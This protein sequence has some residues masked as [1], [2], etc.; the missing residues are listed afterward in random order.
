ME[1]ALSGRQ[2][3]AGS[4]HTSVICGAYVINTRILGFQV[5]LVP[6]N[7]RERLTSKGNEKIKIGTRKRMGNEFTDRATVQV[8]FGSHFSFSSSLW[9]LLPYSLLL[10]TELT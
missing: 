9:S 1:S 2:N 8:K 6:P 5:P 4:M 10:K 7:I 3:E